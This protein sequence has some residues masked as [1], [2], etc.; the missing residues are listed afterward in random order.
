MRAELPELQLALEGR[1][2]DHHA[3]MLRLHLDHVDHPSDMVDRLGEEADHAVGP[4]LEPMRRLQTSPGVGK[5]T[6][7]VMLAEMG[8]DMTRVPTPQQLASWAGLCPL[9]TTN[10][11]A[12]AA[13]AR[14]ARATPLR[15]ALWEAAWVAPCTKGTYLSDPVRPVPSPS[16][17]VRQ[18]G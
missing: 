7:E 6:A 2:N 17:T 11:V 3:L 13:P 8:A 1:F 15:T 14:P 4:F 5:R 18:A 12:N 10:P 9:E 16:A